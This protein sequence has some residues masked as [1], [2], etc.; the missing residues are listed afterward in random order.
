MINVAYMNRFQRLTPKKGDSIGKF[1]KDE[2]IEKSL[3]VITFVTPL[4]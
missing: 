1:I 3:Y 2:D 4:G